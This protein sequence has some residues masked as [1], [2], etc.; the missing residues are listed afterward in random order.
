MPYLKLL[1]GAVLE[2]EAG[3]IDGPASRPYPVAA[4][5][6]LA[7]APSRRLSRGKL[8]GFLWPDSSEKSA[9]GRL[10]TCAYQIRSDLGEEVLV[11]V[12]DD[13]WLNERAVGCDVFR[14]E[15]ALEAGAYEKA[16]Q[17]YDG[18][19]LDGFEGPGST[20]F[21]RHV[22]GERARLR[23]AYGSALEALGAEAEAAEDFEAAARWWRKRANEDPYNSK[24]AHRL[25]QALAKAG[26]P[27]GAVQVAHVHEQLLDQQ[28]G[29]EPSAEVRALR[30][31]L[32][33]GSR[34]RPTVSADGAEAA[35]AEAGAA[36]AEEPPEARDEQ[37]TFVPPSVPARESVAGASS[38]AAGGVSGPAGRRGRASTTRRRS[39]KVLLTALVALGILAAGAVGGWY[40][41]GAGGSAPSSVRERTIAVLPFEELG[42]GEASVFTE[43]LHSDLSTR[44][45]TVRGLGVISRGSVLQ[46]RDAEKPL[47][48]IG[49][50]LGATWVVRGEVQRAGNEVQLNVRLVDAARDRQVWSESYRRTW[51]AQNLFEIQA[52]I[53]QEIVR[54]L[55]IELTSEE[56]RRLQ[57]VP[58]QNTAAYEL[59]LQAQDLEQLRTPSPMI[60]QRIQLY[61]RALELD[62]TFAEAWA[63]LADIFVAQGWVTSDLAW[64]DSATAA[65]RKALELDPALAAAHAQLGDVHWTLGRTEE[66]IAAYERALELH[67]GERE[68]MNNLSVLLGRRGRYAE[69]MRLLE[70]LHR[71]APDS[72]GPIA[73][74]AALNAQLGRDDVADAWLAYGRERGHS[75]PWTRFHVSLFHRQDLARARE[76]LEELA[77][78]IDDYRLTRRRAALALYAGDWTDA[79]KHYR[80]L[81]PGI[82][83]GSAAVFG[84]LLYDPLGLAFAL[85]RLADPEE[86]RAIAREVVETA[87]QDIAANPDPA[88]RQRMAV[89]HLILGDTTAALDWLEQAVDVGYR[90]VRELRTIP[91][92]APLRDHA[93]FRTLLE[94]MEILLA[95]EL[96]RIEAEGWGL[97]Q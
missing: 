35:P 76:A 15:E 74:L 97:P 78:E 44:L 86:A 59:Y 13:L 70:R 32:K 47:P 25:M 48:E 77:K 24:V 64:V 39:E 40:L 55:E 21:E 34:P 66:A 7:T 96:R 95:E 8:I 51:T 46:F 41:L 92:L 65:A 63:G 89:A 1:G 61:R 12:G 18:P 23:R 75:M 49:R 79:R 17:L 88:P 81:Y 30:E 2:D 62:S 50:E 60:D 82:P 19:F 3:V 73:R 14:F 68:A 38:V 28:F 93:R 58:T 43:G 36:P 31:E 52:D 83:K 71:L 90:D 56:R 4:L 54:A 42:D 53:A 69:K 94:R 85:D 67:S 37:D 80:V 22:E 26:N 91:T 27:A 16:V 9:R 6:L 72:P 20:L 29:T 5:A 11:S 10:N 45:A 57:E 33:A 87:E 84:G